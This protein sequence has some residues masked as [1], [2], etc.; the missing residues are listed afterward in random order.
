[1][2]KKINSVVFASALTCVFAAFAADPLDDSLIFKLGMVGDTNANGRV[3]SG[4]VF[5]AMAVSGNRNDSTVISAHA[6]DAKPL[7]FTNVNYRIGGEGPQRYEH[8]GEDI[9]FPFTIQKRRK[10]EGRDK[11]RSSQWKVVRT[12]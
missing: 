7:A 11:E 8:V 5:N 3:D 12:V 10:G 4:E 9:H 1:M 2:K 6:S